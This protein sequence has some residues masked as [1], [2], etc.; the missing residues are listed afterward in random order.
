MAVLPESPAEEIR[1]LRRCI[2]DLVSVLALPAIWAGGGPS[3]V[4]GNLLDALMSMLD[5]DFIYVRLGDAHGL[6]YSE[7]MRTGPQVQP[8]PQIRELAE[9]LRA[10]LA[11]DSQKTTPVASNF[12]SGETSR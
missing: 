7:M 2:S 8:N 11:E 12:F 10:W 6:E 5:L 4:A 3:H 9:K 1:R